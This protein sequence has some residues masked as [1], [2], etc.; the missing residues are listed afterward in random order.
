MARLGIEPGPG[1]P[2]RATYLN[3]MLIAIRNIYIYTLAQHK[4][5]PSACGYTYMNIHDHT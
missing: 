5:P 1:P 4:A 3:G 2:R